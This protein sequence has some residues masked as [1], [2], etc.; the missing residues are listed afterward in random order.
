M[1]MNPKNY[2]ERKPYR[3]KPGRNWFLVKISQNNTGVVH[4]G[5]IYMP[6]GLIGKRVMFKIEV[7]E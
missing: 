7:L 4:L 5:P 3:E 2:I 1:I 6:R